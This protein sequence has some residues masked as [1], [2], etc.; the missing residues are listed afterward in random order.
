MYNTD[1]SMSS[2]ADNVGLLV[3]RKLIKRTRALPA[4]SRLLILGLGYSGSRVRALAEAI[5]TEVIAT[6]RQFD[7]GGNLVFDSTTGQR[8][9]TQQLRGVTHMLSCIPPD[10][11]GQEPVLT[12]FGSSLRDLPLQWVGYLS[13]TGVYGDRQGG[14]VDEIDKPRPEQIRSCRRLECERYWQQA[15]LRVPVQILRLP[16]IYGPGRSVLLS[17]RSA[18]TRCIDKPGHKFSRVHV[19]DIAGAV[20]HLITEAEFGRRPEVVNICDDYPASIPEL[21]QYAARLMSCPKPKLQSFDTVAADMTPMALSFWRE[22]RRVSNALLV[23][24]LGY[25]LL[26]PDFRSGLTDCYRQDIACRPKL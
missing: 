23:R 22:H 26:H 5:G 25:R 12:A 4:N 19:D 6:R 3:P 17:L 15:G 11:L 9:T 13:T 20:L 7:K 21:T 24:T 8:P 2:G 10:C 16:G 1:G 18:Q 14:W